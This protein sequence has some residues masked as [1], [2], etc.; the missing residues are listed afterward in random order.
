M[1]PPRACV[2]HEIAASEASVDYG[3]PQPDL[4]QLL[5]LDQSCYCHRSNGEGRN[6]NEGAL[7]AARKIFSF[8]V[9]VRV[10]FVGRTRRHRQHGKDHYGADQ[11]DKGVDTI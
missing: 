7:D 11:I 9:P 4:I 8:A 1:L 3:Q 6:K 2:P 10:D 5:W